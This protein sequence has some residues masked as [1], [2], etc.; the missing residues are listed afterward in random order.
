VALNAEFIGRAYPVS[1][2]YLVGR[3]KIREFALAVGEVNPVF[4][5]SVA[6]RSLGYPDLIAPPTFATVV[7]MESSHVVMFDP[8]L[9]LDFTR[10]V[11]AEQSY[12][13]S[14]PIC[15]GDELVV[16][17]MIDNIRTVAGNDMLTTKASID[18]VDGEHVV[19][20]T[21]VLVSR[22]VDS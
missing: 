16:S 18:T 13:Y 5:D 10:V 14:R 7:A 15:A 17:T 3:E 11:H 20:A 21:S 1:S 2:P 4:F 19:T 22:G 12:A 8:D 6:A 9:G